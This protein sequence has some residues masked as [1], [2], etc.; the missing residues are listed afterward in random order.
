[1]SGDESYDFEF[2]QQ[3][4]ADNFQEFPS[5]FMNYEL[6]QSLS[7]KTKSMNI[8]AGL[9][10]NFSPFRFGFSVALPYN[11]SVEENH[12]T[13]E[14]L[15]FDNSD[16]SD[17]IQ[18]G[19]Y[20]YRILMPATIDFGA[21]LVTESNLTLSMAFRIQDWSKMQFNLKDFA[22]DSDEYIILKNEN[23]SI[24]EDY[25]NVSQL[26]FGGEYLFPITSTFGCV[27]RFGLAYIPSPKTSGSEEKAVTSVGLGVPI[28][29]RFIFDMAYLYSYQKKESSDAYV[30]SYVDEEINK[31]QF[32]FNLSY[33][34]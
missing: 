33:L 5:D 29:N 28:Y 26:R 10:Y 18:L 4:V 27:V 20:D 22:S 23:E 24:V 9:K 30:P 16:Y 2:L 8:R 21:A 17:A 14:R 34:F 6:F 3:D 31:N 11:I 32:L 1:M 25:K 13:Q 19:Y 15:I 12:G 7:T